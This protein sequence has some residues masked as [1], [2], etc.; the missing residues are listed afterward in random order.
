MM[1]ELGV[2][3]GCA[4]KITV[5]FVS[6]SAG[7][8]ALFRRSAVPLVLKETR[9]RPLRVAVPVAGMAATDDWLAS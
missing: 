7:I 2:V 5:R 6:P 4:T 9:F 1:S 8:V 3:N